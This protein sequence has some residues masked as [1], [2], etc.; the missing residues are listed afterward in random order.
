MKV[1]P[2]VSSVPNSR[3][4]PP[5]VNVVEMLAQNPVVHA[6]AFGAIYAKG[7][8]T[9]PEVAKQLISAFERAKKKVRSNSASEIIHSAVQNLASPQ[10]KQFSFHDAAIAALDE[11]KKRLYSFALIYACGTEVPLGK[12]RK[13]ISTL[14]QAGS[15]LPQKSALNFA[16]KDAL[17]VLEAQQAP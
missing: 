6:K 14:N 3:W 7:V 16:V 1:L 8:K 13:V 5:H 17:E 11:D 12:V 2:V 15:G 9:P 4:V 10:E